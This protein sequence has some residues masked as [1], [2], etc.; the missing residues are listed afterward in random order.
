MLVCLQEGLDSGSCIGAVPNNSAEDGFTS[1]VKVIEKPE[2]H[3]I[4]VEEEP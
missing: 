4:L 3:F 2:T 1:G